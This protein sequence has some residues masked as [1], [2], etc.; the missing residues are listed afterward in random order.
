[1]TDEQ[2][3][4]EEALTES[5]TARIS[6]LRPSDL[7]ADVAAAVRALGGEAQRVEI[8]DRALVIG[9]WSAEELAVVS[10][11]SGASRRYHLRTLADYAV[12]V[13]KDRGVLTEGAARGRWRLAQSGV[14][15]RHPYGRIFTAAVGVAGNP[16]DDTWSASEQTHLWFSQRSFRVSRGDHVFVLAAGRHS[17][18]VGLFEV[19]SSGMSR[20]PENPWDPERWPWAIAVRPLASVPPAEAVSVAS[21]TA[22]RATAQVISDR[23]RQE[24]LY[25]AVDAYAVDPEVSGEPAEESA[26]QRVTAVRRA[27]NFDPDRRPAP[28]ETDAAMIDAEESLALQEKAR[29]GHHT[30]L[31]RL[32]SYLGRTGWTEL[33]EIPAAIDLRGQT[34]GGQRVIF[35]GKT[36]RESNETSQCRSA[37][38]QL[39]EYRLE[40]GRPSD[41]LC[42]AVD[43]PLSPRRA[44]ILDRLGIPLVLAQADEVLGLNN[45]G[46][47]LLAGDAS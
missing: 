40:Y 13:C 2:P 22:P 9:G 10:W 21:V 14:I 5:V 23:D 1:M 30:L 28:G 8:I 37:V 7:A 36:I 4:S 47:A 27:R 46:A 41:I 19:T 15:E 39:L 24:G 43:A 6:R 33:D 3:T 38:A 12:T 11:Y 44:E 17:A 26:E 29:Q 35:E 20:A 34:P 42:L 18:V 32:H 25:E 31:V 16:V 45:S